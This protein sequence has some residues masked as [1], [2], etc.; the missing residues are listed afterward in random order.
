MAIVN[1]NISSVNFDPLLYSFSSVNRYSVNLEEKVTE[2]SFSPLICYFW[3]RHIRRQPDFP[4]N[5]PKGHYL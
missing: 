2:V 4:Q 3:P 5:S 1:Q